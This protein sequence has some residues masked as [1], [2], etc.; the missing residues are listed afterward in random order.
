MRLGRAAPFD[1]LEAYLIPYV[2]AELAQ[3]LMLTR[4]PMRTSGVSVIFLLKVNV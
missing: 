4:P 1:G 2:R 3:G